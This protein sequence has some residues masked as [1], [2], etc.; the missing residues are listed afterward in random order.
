MAKTIKRF[1][2]AF[3]AAVLVLTT[4]C[5]T[6]FA[7]GTINV[8]VSGDYGS[9]NVSYSYSV[10]ELPITSNVGFVTNQRTSS[11]ILTF[12]PASGSSAT[13]F[14][15]ERGKDDNPLATLTVP[16]SVGGMPSSFT[17]SVNLGK[18]KSVYVIIESTST[19]KATGW[20]TVEGVFNTYDYV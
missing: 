13:V 2:A 6:A 1:T 20:V 12:S 5:T 16:K 9:K 14:F 15:Y 10:D 7:D 18:K 3:L 11:Y 17:A 19:I 8:S 4:L